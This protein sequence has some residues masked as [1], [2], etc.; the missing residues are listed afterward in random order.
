MDNGIE[1]NE[2]VFIL[3]GV[4]LY[5]H[6]VMIEGVVSEKKD[7][8]CTFYIYASEKAYGEMKQPVKIIEETIPYD[9]SKDLEQQAYDYISGLDNF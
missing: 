5:S 2:A 4:N 7:I 9:D 1:L 6:S 8:A 3:R